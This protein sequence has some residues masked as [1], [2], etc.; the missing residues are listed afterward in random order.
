VSSKST[1]RKKKPVAEP[2][3]ERHLGVVKGV[4]QTIQE[5]M[6]VGF[7]IGWIAALRAA[8]DDLE[9]ALVDAVDHGVE[10]ESFG[11]Q[12]I[13]IISHLGHLAANVPDLNVIIARHGEI[14][15]EILERMGAPTDAVRH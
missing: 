6:L 9:A 10:R 15:D 5:A 13:S 14:P 4:P 8:A 1:P 7:K 11:V 3:V 12:A 2:E